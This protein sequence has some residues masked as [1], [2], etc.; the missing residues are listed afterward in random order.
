MVVQYGH[1]GMFSV[2]VT[3]ILLFSL[4]L[5]L[6]SPFSPPPSRPRLAPSCLPL[7]CCAALPPALD[8]MKDVAGMD[9]KAAFEAA[10]LKGPTSALPTHVLPEPPAAT[11]KIEGGND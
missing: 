10:G 11:K 3:G 1:V 7:F 8:M 4:I 6:P 5:S 2:F 9:I